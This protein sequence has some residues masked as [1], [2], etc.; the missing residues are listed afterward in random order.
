MIH[1]TTRAMRISLGLHGA[2]AVCA[3]LWWKLPS[4][5]GLTAVGNAGEIQPLM[6][7]FEREPEPPAAPL[8]LETAPPEPQ[9]DIA[10][11][12]VAPILGNSEK[13]CIAMS[14]PLP[15]WAAA[16]DTT[17]GAQTPAKV[18]RAGR[19]S[20]AAGHVSGPAP[21]GGSGLAGFL[22]PRY[23]RS[24]PPEYPFEAR[25]EKREGIVLLSVKV[26]LGGSPTAISLRHGSGI[27][28]L[29]EAAIRAVR[30]WLFQPATLGGQPFAAVVEVPVRF[31]LTS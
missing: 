5:N 27:R 18:A 23:L 31:H 2:L 14:I 20:R 4:G 21:V 16:A 26:G 25:R 13:N 1:S 7:S 19:G 11:A 8:Q 12:S 28:A 3:L 24:P 30:S 17:A 29:D 10:P 6:A 15:F 22:P 9:V